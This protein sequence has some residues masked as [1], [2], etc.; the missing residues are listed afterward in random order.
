MQ[1]YLILNVATTDVKG[2]DRAATQPLQTHVSQSF[3]V[4]YVEMV[5]ITQPVHT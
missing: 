5:Q 2:A 3:T 1:Q 4:T